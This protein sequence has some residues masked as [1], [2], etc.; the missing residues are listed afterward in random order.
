MSKLSKFVKEWEDCDRCPLC[1][2]R[3]KVSNV[4]GKF[5]SDVLFIGE[6]PGIGE[7]VIGRPMSGPAGKYFKHLLQQVLTAD[8]CLLELRFGFT[9]LLGCIPRKKPG[10]DKM[11]KLPSEPLQACSDRLVQL[12]EIAKPKV[13]VY[14]G[15]TAEKHGATLFMEYAEDSITVSHP[16]VLMRS[17]ASTKIM[18]EQK[19]VLEL[20]EFFYER[21][22]S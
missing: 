8:E 7:D 16:A 1:E 4:S 9:D 19:L 20:S 21:F 2:V 14:V 3:K 11:V 13:I 18:A 12:V 6:A 15:K 5:P 22:R 17:D 10:G